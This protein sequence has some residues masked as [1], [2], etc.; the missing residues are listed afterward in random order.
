[1]WPMKFHMPKVRAFALLLP[2]KFLLVGKNIVQSSENLLI[3]DSLVDITVNSEAVR[4]NLV[5]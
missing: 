5:G 3:Q 4:T 1:M 2:I